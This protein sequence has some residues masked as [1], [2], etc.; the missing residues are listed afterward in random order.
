MNCLEYENKNTFTIAVS[1][2]SQGLS[3]QAIYPV[4]FQP[5]LMFSQHVIW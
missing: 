5:L 1:G 4:Q 3:L 2:K